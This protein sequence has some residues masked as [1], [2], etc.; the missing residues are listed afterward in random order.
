MRPAEV[1]LLDLQIGAGLKANSN[2]LQ[3]M[4][5]ADGFKR[6]T[7]LMQW[8]AFT[9]PPVAQ[10]SS[11]G[12]IASQVAH[13]Q[14][15]KGG[16]PKGG[17]KSLA[18]RSTHTH[19]A[20]GTSLPVL[21]C[22]CLSRLA[23]LHAANLHLCKNAAH[24]GSIAFADTLCSTTQQNSLSPSLSHFKHGFSRLFMSEPCIA[25][26]QQLFGAR[27][28]LLKLRVHHARV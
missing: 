20:R 23:G 19:S 22:F 16:S 2:N 13:S 7:Q 8:A 1:A 11:H 26:L 4:C 9:F 15:H 28:Q 21:L 17:L 24:C 27:G 10:H 12:P 6:I 14:S 18:F 5:E 25:C 3:T